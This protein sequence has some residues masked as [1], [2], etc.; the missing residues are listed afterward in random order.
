MT[1]KD[2]ARLFNVFD[3]DHS[4]S[5]SY[6]EFLRGVVGDMND[7]RKATCMKAFA[8]IDVDKSGE[9]TIED[10]K[11]LYNAKKNPKVISGEKTEDEVLF[12]FLDTFEVHHT[13]LHG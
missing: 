3:T 13:N 6:D 5:I 12:E 9:I 4:G 1:P 8:K 2:S 10:V 7:R 11:H